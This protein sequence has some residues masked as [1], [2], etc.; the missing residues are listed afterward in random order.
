[1]PRGRIK[2]GCAPKV[3]LYCASKYILKMPYTTANKYYEERR[4][5]TGKRG[6]MGKVGPK[7]LDSCQILQL[8]DYVGKRVTKRQV[9]KAMIGK[10]L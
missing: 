2:K 8:A 5:M 7:A 10:C 4:G 6:K 1:M 3:S 9:L